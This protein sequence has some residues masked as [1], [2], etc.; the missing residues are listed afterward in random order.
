M[1]CRTYPRYRHFDFAPVLEEI[2]K[3]EAAK[4]ELKKQARASLDALLERIGT[5]AYLTWCDECL[6]NKD[7]L[8]D[9]MRKADDYLATLACPYCPFDHDP[10]CCGVCHE[11][12]LSEAKAEYRE[13]H[14]PTNPRV[15]FNA[16]RI[17]FRHGVIYSSHSR[18]TPERIARVERIIGHELAGK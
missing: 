7:S 2:A 6:E 9:I 3:T 1:T 16:G 14:K 11:H 17:M 15:Y 8:G 4:T 10:G 12:E 13:R 18:A 5:E